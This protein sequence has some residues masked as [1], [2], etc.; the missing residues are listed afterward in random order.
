[1]SKNKTLEELKRSLQDDLQSIQDREKKELNE[2]QKKELKD[3]LEKV[4]EKALLEKGK[5]KHILDKVIEDKAEFLKIF[6]PWQNNEG[7]KLIEKFVDNINKSDSNIYFSWLDILDTDKQWKKPDNEDSEKEVKDKHKH[8]NMRY[9][10]PTHL[11]G[12]IDNA[13][14]FHCME[15]PRGYLGNWKDDQIDEEFAGPNLEE[16]YIKSASKRKEESNTIKD[17]IKER[18]QIQDVSYNSITKIIYSYTS[19][20]ARELNIMFDKFEDSDYK[21]YDFS[22]GSSDL[23]DY[24]YFKNYYKQFFLREDNNLEPFKVE[25][26]QD[27]ALEC[28]NKICNLEIY[29]FSCAQPSLDKNG[30]GKKILENSELSRL[31]AYIVLRGIYKYLYKCEQSKT[32]NKEEPQKPVF[33][34]RKYYRAWKPLFKKIF[35]EVKVEN[36]FLKY[37]EDHFFYCQ[38]GQQ[39]GGI[40]SGNVISVHD[41]EAWKNIYEKLKEIAFT[42]ISDLITKSDNEQ[43]LKD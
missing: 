32:K 37:L 19:P 5:S 15:N 29:P 22:K 24:Y 40:T 20:L 1:M 39:G 7:K 17:I 14:I 6:N 13:M 41:L 10:I 43:E 23:E 12:D 18:Y 25:E 34:F 8:V 33:I 42:E 3:V 28:A 27:K 21:T 30:I 31:S 11:H 26:Y 36:R 35:K 38:T 2:E 16:F 4:F 9:Q